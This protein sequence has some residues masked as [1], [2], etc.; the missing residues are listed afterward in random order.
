[1][2]VSLMSL[3]ADYLPNLVS[4]LFALLLG[5]PFGLWLDRLIQ[6]RNKKDLRKVLFNALRDETIY[7]IRQMMNILVA[8]TPEVKRTRIPVFYLSS[9]AWTSIINGQQIDVL[10]NTE[11]LQISLYLYRIIDRIQMNIRRSEIFRSQE[12]VE[13]NQINLEIIKK[14]ITS[15]AREGLDVG[16]SFLGKLDEYMKEQKTKIEGVSEVISHWDNQNASH[17]E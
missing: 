5:I 8:S 4:G 11:I 3:L 12:D 7:N 9:S 15:S 1:M 10:G 2:I 17:K 6:N 13:N 16:I 14:M